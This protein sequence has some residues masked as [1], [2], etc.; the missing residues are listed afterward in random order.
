[1]EKTNRT[2]EKGE[3]CYMKEYGPRK[4]E[5]NGEKAFGFMPPSS[6]RDLCVLHRA[7]AVIERPLLDQE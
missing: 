6:A 7:F 5:G 1:M 2:E 3:T 4:G